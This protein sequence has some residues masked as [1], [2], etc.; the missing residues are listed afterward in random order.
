MSGFAGRNKGLTGQEAA[1]ILQDLLMTNSRYRRLVETFHSLSSLD[2]E[3]FFLEALKTEVEQ[4]VS[5]ELRA[6]ELRVE[7][8]RSTQARGRRQ[9]ETSQN[10]QESRTPRPTPAGDTKAAWDTL[11]IPPSL[12]ETLQAYCRILHD[13]KDYQA[14]G[15]HLPKGL[16]LYGPPGCGKT[17]IAKTLSAKAGLHFIALSTSDCK[18]MW[19][20]HSADRLATV[21]SDARARQ[22]TLL[23]IDELDA[24]CPPRG[25]YADAISQEFTAQLLQ[26]VDGTY[27]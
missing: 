16:L 14:Q 10:A 6:A 9:Q 20:G 21:F 3:Y 27:E 22:P 26:E 13:Y 23:F 5:E 15:V 19:L 25:A 2:G 11:V 18:A 8:L 7:E 4:K 1:G 12:K 24:V 17:Q